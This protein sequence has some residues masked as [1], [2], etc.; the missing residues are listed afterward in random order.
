M[1]CE[2]HPFI[3]ESDDDYARTISD[4]WECYPP[5]VPQFSSSL[6]EDKMIADSD[7]S[8]AS[9]N[10]NPQKEYRNENKSYGTAHDF[11]DFDFQQSRDQH[12]V[13]SRR[14]SLGIS[15]GDLLE[16]V[17]DGDGTFHSDTDSQQRDYGQKNTLSITTENYHNFCQG[18]IKNTDEPSQNLDTFRPLSK[19]ELSQV[20]DTSLYSTSYEEASFSSE[21]TGQ[22]DAQK[23]FYDDHDRIERSSPSQSR[24]HQGTSLKFPKKYEEYLQTLIEF[25]D[26]SRRTRSKVNKIKT[27]MKINKPLNLSHPQKGLSYS[28]IKSA[29]RNARKQTTSSGS[30]KFD[31]SSKFYSAQEDN[32]TLFV[33]PSS[34]SCDI[35]SPQNEFLQSSKLQR[36]IVRRRSSL[37]LKT[38]QSGFFPDAFEF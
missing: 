12:R 18:G 23:G 32:S 22:K 29:K 8:T 7:S 33:P 13:H 15:A 14:N 19:I 26:D 9:T 27:L 5:S 3:D 38:F 28:S 1:Y 24:P 6:L 11:K 25:M 37:A 34:D 20:D 16:F 2:Q 17:C 35:L 30:N 36:G 4:S 10:G 31:S 21:I